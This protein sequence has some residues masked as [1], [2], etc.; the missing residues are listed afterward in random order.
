MAE[1]VLGL[2]LL[3]DKYV[4]GT[5]IFKNIPLEIFSNSQQINVSNGTKDFE[6]VS[7]NFE[8]ITFSYIKAQHTP[9]N[10]NWVIWLAQGWDPTLPDNPN[11]PVIIYGGSG[12]SGGS[13]SDSP[14]CTSNW[15]KTDNPCNGNGDNMPSP[16]I[17]TTWIPLNN[18]QVVS[19]QNNITNPCLVEVFNIINNDRYKDGIADM[20]NKLTNDKIVQ[21][22]FN[23][24]TTMPTGTMP[25]GVYAYTQGFP[26]ITITFNTSL[27]SHCS[28]EYV[29]NTFFHEVIH[30]YMRA[31][32]AS[33]S[34]SPS[35][36]H[37][38]M[39][40]NYLQELV[41]TVMQI[42]PNLTEKNAWC[43]AFEGLVPDQTDNQMDINYLNMARIAAIQK[44]T[45]L[46][47][48]LNSEAAIFAI[49]N[50]YSETGTQGT[51]TA[52]CQ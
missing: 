21:V 2:F 41:N 38:L 46:Y 29:T 44:I 33:W 15:Y 45:E 1:Q 3:M 6:I 43:I 13:G 26:S 12:G 30:A 11:P 51:R 32:M 23:E 16:P 34:I 17:I 48:S 9:I 47:P 25:P 8:Y 37:N 4:F 28:Q 19:I 31:Y 20:L 36:E 42:F 18:N 24:S 40:Q 5:E 49:A 27:L 7:Y 39:I 22:V 10:W 50:S 14:P 35:A 52:N